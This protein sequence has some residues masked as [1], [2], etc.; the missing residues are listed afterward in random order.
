MNAAAH[1]W[2][3]SAAN[4]LTT[5][6]KVDHND[7]YRQKW[8]TG[9]GAR[10]AA[11]IRLFVFPFAGGDVSAFYHLQQWLPD[12]CE[13]VRVQLPGRGNRRNDPMP[14]SMADMVRALIHPLSSALEKPFVFFGY[15]MG[16]LIA[17]ELLQQFKRLGLA[18][19]QLFCV[20]ACSAPH[21]HHHQWS[22]MSDREIIQV[23]TDSDSWLQDIPIAQLQENLPLIKKDLLFCQAYTHSAKSLGEPLDCPLMT[24]AGAQ[25]A[26]APAARVLDWWQYTTASCVSRCIA[27][28]HFFLFDSV[29]FPRIILRELQSLLSVNTFA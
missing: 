16:A 4:A 22:E 1:S 12:T 7:Y 24:I 8:L 3:R 2:T 27:G 20:A 13:L 5:N 15:S 26:I 28:G 25:D 19:P 10:P 18:K 9:L 14:N 23:L 11:N 17:Y 29:Q 6:N 21:L